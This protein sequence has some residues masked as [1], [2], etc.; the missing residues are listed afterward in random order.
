[1][2][3]SRCRLLVCALAAGG[4]AV[5]IGCT[6]VG[7]G[8][9]DLEESNLAGGDD[10]Y[11]PAYWFFPGIGFFSPGCTASLV[12]DRDVLT[13]AHCV[14]Y[15]GGW[16]QTVVNTGHPDWYVRFRDVNGESPQ[17]YAIERFT[18]WGTAE[19]ND[20][21]ALVRLD[22]SVASWVA[23]PLRIASRYPDAWSWMMTA[24]YGCAPDYGKRAL[25]W[26]LKE[27]WQAGGHYTNEMGVCPGDSGGPTVLG[28][29]DEIISVTSRGVQNQSGVCTSGDH[30]ALLSDA[31]GYKATLEGKMR[32]WNDEICGTRDYDPT[33]CDALGCAYYACTGH[34]LPRGTDC[35][36]E[37]GNAPGQCGGTCGANDT[38]SYC[39]QFNGN[40]G[41]CDSQGGTC[42]YYYCT[43]ECLAAGQHDCCA[44]CGNAP[45]H[46]G[47]TCGT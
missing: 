27:A 25:S 32:E 12:S 2:D 43:S 36:A 47:G 45:G 33:G 41:Q 44:V 15:E 8:G 9:G 6:V 7:G 30:C 42:A 37:C 4:W 14:G 34:C 18:S 13:A 46:C 5:S 16:G 26:T 29:W 21:I 10:F 23:S 3:K 35:C 40:V 17:D 1:M 24:G 20:D 38:D 31:V 11:D 19:T 22:R 28:G 39:R